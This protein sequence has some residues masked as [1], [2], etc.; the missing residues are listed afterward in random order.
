MRRLY[1]GLLVLLVILVVYN[2]PANSMEMPAEAISVAGE[3]TVDEPVVKHQTQKTK[4]E[5]EPVVLPEATYTW[6]ETELDEMNIVEPADSYAF[7]LSFTDDQVVVETDCNHGVSSYS[8][9]EEKVFIFGIPALTKR[10]CRDS[11]ESEYLK[12]LADVRSYNLSDEGVLQF[13][14]KDGGSMRFE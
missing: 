14:L 3:E 7:T 13:K 1:V 8:A 10:S 12:M 11:Q 6:I 5:P 4:A 9:N 2:Q